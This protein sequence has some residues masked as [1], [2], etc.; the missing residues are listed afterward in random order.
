MIYICEKMKKILDVTEP[1]I[2]SY[3]A[4]ANIL[5]LLWTQKDQ[6]MPWLCDHLIQLIIRPNNVNAPADFYDHADIN[7][8]YSQIYGCTGLDWLRTKPNLVASNTFTDYMEYVIENGFCLEPCLDRYYFKFSEYYK[9]KHFIH[10]TLIYGFNSNS[11]EVYISDFFENGK[12][13]RKTISYDEVNDSIKGNDWL[14]NLYGHNNESYKCNLNMLSDYLND[15]LE[16]RDSFQKFKYSSSE[17]N[18]NVSFGVTFYDAITTNLF[19]D[20]EGLDIR[21]FHILTD[22]K[23]LMNL[24]LCYL[25]ANGKFDK[26]QMEELIKDNDDLLHDSMTLRNM[27]IYY[28]LKKDEK[29]FNKIQEKKEK[30]KYKDIKFVQKFINILN[31]N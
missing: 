5:S 20:D 13:C 7:G 6:T 12:Y 25:K 8:Y 18:K 27:V 24:R 22:H 28:N 4:I 30:L 16:S 19:F 14:V 21:P 3:P 2:T 23:R 26:E 17:R 1:P 9:K 11:K 10:S 31:N 29:S 15:Y